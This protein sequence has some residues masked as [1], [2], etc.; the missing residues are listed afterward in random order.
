MSCDLDIATLMNHHGEYRNVSKFSDRQVWANSADPDQTAPSSLIRVYTVCN[1]GCVFWM[2]YSKEK[3]SCSTFRVIT[4][5][6]LGVRNFRVFTVTSMFLKWKM[7]FPFL[8]Y[9]NKPTNTTKVFLSGKEFYKHAA[10]I[11]IPLLYPKFPKYSDTPNICCNHS[12]IWTMWL[13]HRVMIPNDAD[14]MA[15]SVDLDQEQSDLG[16]HCLPRHICPKIWDHYG[17]V[18]TYLLHVYVLFLEIKYV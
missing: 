2:H 17:I 6:V 14:G 9:C 11:P 16:L 4:A 18:R 8:V 13:Y 12:K 3:S 10:F 1:S 5:N 15:N 7:L